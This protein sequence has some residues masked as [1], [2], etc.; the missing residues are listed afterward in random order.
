MSRLH[1]PQR[2]QVGMPVG[3]GVCATTG[4]IINMERANDKNRTRKNLGI[5]SSVYRL[6]LKMQ[7]SIYSI[8]WKL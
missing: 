6:H 4:V 7:S 2:S 8:V 1:Q 5:K 3:V